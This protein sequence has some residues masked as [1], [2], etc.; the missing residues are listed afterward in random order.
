VSIVTRYFLDTEFQENGTS[1]DLLS[2]GVVCDD[3]REFYACNQN[4][5]LDLVT[6]WV[7]ENVLPELPPYGSV[8]W[9]PKTSIACELAEFVQQ[10]AERAEFW[11]YY[12]A[13]DWVVVC[14]LYGAMVTLPRGF[15]KHCMDLKQASVMAGNPEHPKQEKGKHNALEDARWARDL[16]QFLVGGPTS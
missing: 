8:V 16:W 2:I 4:A 12:S 9:M 11:G 3:G 15:P 1:I 5:R 7:R 10:G 13:Y 6:P 14:Q